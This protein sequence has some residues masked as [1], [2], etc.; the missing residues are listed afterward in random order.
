MR[1]VDKPHQPC[2]QE[3]HESD[4]GS[5]QPG[6]GKMCIVCVD[7]SMQYSNIGLK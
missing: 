4:I 5:S 6:V 2:H 1:R 7:R 3:A